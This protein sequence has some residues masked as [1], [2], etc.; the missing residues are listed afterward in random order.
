MV[1]ESKFI[2]TYFLNQQIEQELETIKLNLVS[3]ACTSY[4]QYQYLIGVIE[5][6]EKSKTILKDIANKYGDIDNEEDNK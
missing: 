3:G 4:D 5:G 1:P 2:D 6:M